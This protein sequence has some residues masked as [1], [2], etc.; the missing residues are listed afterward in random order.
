MQNSL[1]AYTMK[2]NENG[3]G[4]L[5]P[6]GH[7]VRFYERILKYKLNKINGNLLDFGCGNGVHSAYFQSKGFKT[8]GIDIVPSLKEIWEQ[9]ISGGGYCKIIEPNSSIKGLFDENMDIIFANQSLYYIPLKELKQNILEFYELLNT[10]GILFATMMSKKNYYFSHSQ[11]EE[12]NG[13]SKVEINGRLNE[14]SFIHFIDKAEDLKNLFQPFETLFLG[15]YDPI[16]FY[17]F[18]GSAHH[19]IYIGIKK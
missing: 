2:Y 12:K 7:V 1:E 11:K 13:L 16:N 15:D 3:Y 14:T 6:D 8:F 9:N 10:G 19:Y 4:L 17:N 5:F 18:E